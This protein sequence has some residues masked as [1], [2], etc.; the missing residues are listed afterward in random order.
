MWW[1]LVPFTPCGI[2]FLAQGRRRYGNSLSCS[3][4]PL[5][6]L[7]CRGDAPGCSAKLSQA[8]TSQF[9]MLLVFF[10]P[11]FWESSQFARG[12]QFFHVFYAGYKVLRLHGSKQNGCM[13]KTNA[14]FDVKFIKLLGSIMLVVSLAPEMNS[15]LIGPYG[16]IL[17]HTGLVWRW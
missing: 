14:T 6:L 13:W 8:R 1:W 9:E 10:L 5:G 4:Q 17:V 11:D 16:F 2:L 12:Q 15:T 3:Q 7:Y